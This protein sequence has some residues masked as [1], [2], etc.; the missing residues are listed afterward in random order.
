LL[1]EVDTDPDV[2]GG[3][4]VEAQIDVAVQAIDQL[5]DLFDGYPVRNRVC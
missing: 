2:S 4:T 5:A 3:S 1:E